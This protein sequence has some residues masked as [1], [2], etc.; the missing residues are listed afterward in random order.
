MADAPRPSS[1]RPVPSGCEGDSPSY[2]LFGPGRGH[3]FLLS[4]AERETEA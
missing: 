2:N 3:R 1:T 4:S